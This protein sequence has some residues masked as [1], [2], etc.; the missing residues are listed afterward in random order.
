MHDLNLSIKVKQL[1][2][3]SIDINKKSKYILKVLKNN[4]DIDDQIKKY[5][6]T[7][8]QYESVTKLIYCLCNNIILP[9]CKFC[10]K[11]LTYSQFKKNKIAVCS[12]KCLN[13]LNKRKPLIHN[14][15]KYFK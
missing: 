15:L 1:F 5:L 10:N 2:T 6:N 13:N 9:K 12:N 3:N 11:Q 14:Y 4:L 8:K 7:H